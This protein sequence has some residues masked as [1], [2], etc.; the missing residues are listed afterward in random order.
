MATISLSFVAGQTVTHTKTVTSQHLVRLLAA[1]RGLRSIPEA[2]DAEVIQYVA[3]EFFQHLKSRVKQHE[4]RVAS[5]AAEAGVT[6]IA[7]T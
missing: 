7:L 4:N 2:T 6:E 3:D 1:E 5:Q